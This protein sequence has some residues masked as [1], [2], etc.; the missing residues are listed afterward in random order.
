MAD[1]AVYANSTNGPV[2]KGDRQQCFI[3]RLVGY[4]FYTDGT[5]NDLLY[6]KT[7]NGGSSWGSEVSVS[8]R[9]CSVMGIWFDKWTPGLTG[10]RIHIAYVDDTSHDVYFNYL[11]TASDTLGTEAAVFN[12]TSVAAQ[13]RVSIAK[14]RGGNLYLLY[15]IDGGDE[16]GLL[17]SVDNG[18][19]WTART[20]PFEGA[21]NDYASIFPGN[22][23]DTND[24]WIIYE[25]RINELSLKVHDDSADSNAE[26]AIA[27][28][29]DSLPS[30]TGQQFS[31][32]VRHSDNHLIV[33]VFNAYDSATGDLKV[34][35]IASAASITEMTDVIT[36][37]DDCYNPCILI[38]QVTDDIYVGYLGQADGGETVGVSVTPHYQMSD[39]G[40]T[41]WSGETTYGETARNH[42]GMLC[43]I[44]SPSS[45]FIPCFQDSANSDLYVNF[46][47]SVAVGA[48][49]GSPPGNSGNAPGR[50]RGNPRPGGGGGGGQGGGGIGNPLNKGFLGTRRRTR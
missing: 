10:T 18:A 29:V 6:K 38:D 40:G 39:D 50:N 46:V 21:T 4:Q 22:E 34:F 41:T 25:D 49:G 14:M 20:S 45:R 31:G 7:T 9:L 12:G 48:V 17:R 16:A 27:A 5:S 11:D 24:A 3:S 33:V 47:N 44:G 15:D 30:T 37:K 19:N 28:V 2:I 1:V 8:T 36:D 26:T 35:D 43:D 13:S 42:I 23:T 32:A